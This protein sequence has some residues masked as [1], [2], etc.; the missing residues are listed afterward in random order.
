MKACFS[1]SLLLLSVSAPALAQ[2]PAPAA[3]PAQ[4]RALEGCWRGEGVVMDKPVVISLAARPITQGAMFLVEAQS[5]ATS[6][7]N[8]RYAAHLVFGGRGAPPKD[9]EATA[10]SGFWIDSFGGDFTAS[11]AGSVTKDGFD[12]AYAYPDATFVNRW[13]WKAD[14]LAWSIV[15]KAGSAPEAAFASYELRRAPCAESGGSK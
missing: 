2:D 14:R 6:D 15:A 3:V 12:V 8:D 10:I 11:G 4:V 7:P 9:G 1:L 5:H 13:R